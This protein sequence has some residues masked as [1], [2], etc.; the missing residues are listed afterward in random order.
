MG[1]EKRRSDKNPHEQQR[2]ENDRYQPRPPR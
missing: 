2:D 1:A